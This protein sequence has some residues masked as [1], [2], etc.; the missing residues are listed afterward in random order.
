MLR[1]SAEINKS[2]SY[3]QNDFVRFL[4]TLQTQTL[5]GLQ[6]TLSTLQTQTL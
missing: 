2:T 1:M 6:G 4:H 5:E 3:L